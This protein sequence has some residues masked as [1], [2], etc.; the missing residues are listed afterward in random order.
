M[1]VRAA[2]AISICERREWILT[3]RVRRFAALVGLDYVPLDCGETHDG[4]LLVFE[5]GTNMVVHAM[6]APELFPYKRPQMEKVFAAFRKML[7]ARALAAPTTS[8]AITACG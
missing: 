5:L 2:V 4:K 3:E 1:Q 6:D 7:K 8:G